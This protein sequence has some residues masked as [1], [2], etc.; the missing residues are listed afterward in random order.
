VAGPLV[1]S[2]LGRW[3]RVRQGLLTT[4]AKF[5][6]GELE[7]RPVAHGYSARETML[8][9][10]HEEAIEAGYG[11]MGS[12]DELPPPYDAARFTGRAAIVAVLTEVHERTLDYLR[13]L[14]D[15]ELL[16][17]TVTPWGAAARRIDLLGHVLEHEIHH[18]GELSLML[19]LLGREG[20]DA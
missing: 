7:F 14:S 4:I 18:R 10:A 8:H 9:I 17:E 12:F 3:Q 1:E 2:F 20:L 19:G 11:I 6:D 13:G 5:D 15:A 16:A